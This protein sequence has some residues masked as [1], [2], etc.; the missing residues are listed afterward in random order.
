MT[1]SHRAIG[2]AS[3]DRNASLPRRDDPEWPSQ[4]R[5]RQTQTRSRQWPCRMACSHVGMNEHDAY[6]ARL[7]NAELDA[8]RLG[9]RQ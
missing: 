8:D 5:S 7:S 1:I 2:R 9:R 6:N 4:S 3:N